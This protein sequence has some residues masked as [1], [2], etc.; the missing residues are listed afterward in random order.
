MI[1]IV[2]TILLIFFCFSFSNCKT[3]KKNSGNQKREIR[4][5]LL[6][7]YDDTIHE[8][9]VLTGKDRDSVTLYFAGEYSN[10]SLFIFVND[11]FVEKKSLNTLNYPSK[12]SDF[13][14]EESHLAHE[15][16]KTKVKLK[17]L[18]RNEF[19]QFN[20]NKNYPII[21][22]RYEDGIWKLLFKKSMKRIYVRRV[23]Q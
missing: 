6:M 19:I 4:G 12:E 1:N 16:G 8:G 13:S 10:D 9:Y 2:K 20:L 18:R 5:T 11:I 23:F 15:N 14:G 3:V 17:L 22:V 7:N 21:F